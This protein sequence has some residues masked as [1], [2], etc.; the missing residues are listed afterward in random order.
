MRCC[1]GLSCADL[2]GISDLKCR[3]CFRLSG[4]RVSRSVA[5]IPTMIVPAEGWRIERRA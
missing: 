2:W 3:D 4:T 5:E 1:S